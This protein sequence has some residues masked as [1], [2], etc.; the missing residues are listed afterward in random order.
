M[1]TTAQVANQAL[2]NR[3]VVVA[4]PEGDSERR[5]DESASYRFA[6]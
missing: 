3:H 4:W 2:M 6:D 1:L 5:F